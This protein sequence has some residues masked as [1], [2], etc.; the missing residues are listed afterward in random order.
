[1]L[2]ELFNKVSLPK[3][4]TA[5]E[6]TYLHQTILPSPFPLI[7]TPQ[8][9]QPFSNIAIDRW[10]DANAHDALRED[11]L[12][13]GYLAPS[14]VPSDQAVCFVALGVMQV[15]HHLFVTWYISNVF[16]QMVDDIYLENVTVYSLFIA[17]D[18]PQSSGIDPKYLHS[19]LVAIATFEGH[20][21]DP[22]A[23]QW[24]RLTPLK[25]L[26]FRQPRGALV[27]NLWALAFW[28]DNQIIV[29]LHC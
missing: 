3:L 16:C 25:S 6:S 19:P 2:H 26:L 1:M 21:L 27:E 24:T 11:V 15:S 9:N 17:V 4:P 28:Q 8:F 7:R 29:S 20:K 13:P 14:D 12:V 23:P 22:N 18:I 5:M 10:L